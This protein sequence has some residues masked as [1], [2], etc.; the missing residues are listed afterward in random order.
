MRSHRKPPLSFEDTGS[1]PFQFAFGWLKNFVNPSERGV[2]AGRG[3]EIA[4]DSRTFLGFLDRDPS[5][6]HAFARAYVR[7]QPKMRQ[8][9][10]TYETV[11]GASLLPSSINELR[12]FRGSK[13][14]IAREAI[15]RVRRAFNSMQTIPALDP[16]GRRGRVT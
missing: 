4:T 16:R 5:K 8:F 2:L 15:G 13:Q 11:D 14:N 12:D 10:L 6:K 9:G 3:V 7:S 1:I